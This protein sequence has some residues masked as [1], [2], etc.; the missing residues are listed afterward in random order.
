MDKQDPP[1]TFGVFKPVGHTLLAFHSQEQ[2]HTAMRDLARMGFAASTMVQYSAEEMLSLADG[3]LRGAGPMANFGYELD[4]LH[5]HK[6]LA[7][8]G[9]GFLVV[10]A[11]HEAQAAR[12]ATLVATLQPASAQHYG[13]FLI[14]DLTE[15][16]PGTA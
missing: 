8:Q 5:Q 11:P 15:T 13:R 14:Q 3:E 2:L 1:T 6:S 10:H 9:C 4:L 12:V 7:Q 16:A